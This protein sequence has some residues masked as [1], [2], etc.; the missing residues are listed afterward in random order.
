MRASWSFTAPTPAVLPAFIPASCS[1]KVKLPVTKDEALSPYLLTLNH[2]CKYRILFLSPVRC[3]AESFGSVSLENKRNTIFR[4][5]FVVL[6]TGNLNLQ[7]PFRTIYPLETDLRN[8]E[9]ACIKIRIASNAENFQQHKCL[10]PVNFLF[11]Q[12][13]KFQA[14]LHPAASSLKMHHITALIITPFHTSPGFAAGL[15]SL[16]PGSFGR[17]RT[18]E[19]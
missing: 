10:V 7:N 2:G 4:Q 1:L 3:P 19:S 16:Q 18:Q 11:R 12:S 5:I 15:S 8:Q 9:D 6:N 13:P 14:T 17:E